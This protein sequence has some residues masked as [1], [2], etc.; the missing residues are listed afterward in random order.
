MFTV[1]ASSILP[2]PPQRVFTLACD[3]ASLP[4]WCGILRLDEAQAWTIAIAGVPAMLRPH[5]VSIDGEQRTAV[6]QA[7][8][9]GLMI[10][11][12]L[13][14][15]EHPEGASFHMRT[16]VDFTAAYPHRIAICRKTSR[17]ASDDLARIAWLLEGAVGA[18]DPP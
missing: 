8:G 2:F 9:D 7:V 14:V 17:E 12:E 15:S 13:S 5:T 10:R 1:E 16:S 4:R 6:H 11:W 3:S 18:S